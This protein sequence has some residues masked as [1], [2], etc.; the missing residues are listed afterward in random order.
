MSEP[1][2]LPSAEEL[3]ELSFEQAQERLEQVVRELESGQ[4]PLDRA[5]ALYETGLALRDV[6]LA[7]LTALEGRLETLVQGAD[8]SLTIEESQ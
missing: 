3:A 4:T 2:A 1:T 7:K 5:L 6:C 8:G